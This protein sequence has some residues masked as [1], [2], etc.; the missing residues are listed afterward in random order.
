MTRTTYIRS[1]GNDVRFVL[2]QQAWLYSYSTSSLKQQSAGT[3]MSL[4]LGMLIPSQPV[5]L[6]NVAFLAENHQIPIV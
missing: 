3:H 5:F 1:D 4:H 2:D 6:P